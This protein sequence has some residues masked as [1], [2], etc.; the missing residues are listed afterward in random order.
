MW[1]LSEST[2]RRMFEDI[3]GVL[4]VSHPR[5]LKGKRAPRT[6]LRIP[7]SLLERM[8]QD[9]TRGFGAEVQARRRAI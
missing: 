9:R 4:K 3:P 1:N 2:V 6:I 8:H 5:L 7:A